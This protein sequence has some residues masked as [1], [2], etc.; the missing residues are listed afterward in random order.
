MKIDVQNKNV[1]AQ[2]LNLSDEIPVIAK[3]KAGEI[4]F[5]NHA[6]AE[7]EWVDMPIRV[8]FNGD[9]DEALREVQTCNKCGQSRV[10]VP[11]ADWGEYDWTEWSL[12]I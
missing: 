7:S 2:L 8:N 4:V 6:G 1:G 10:K 11:S 3:N 9:V 5:C 12:A